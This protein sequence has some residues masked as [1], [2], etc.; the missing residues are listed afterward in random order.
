L[1][2]SLHILTSSMVALNDD[3]NHSRFVVIYVD[4]DG[5]PISFPLGNDGLAL[6]TSFR[7]SLRFRLSEDF[8]I[9]DEEVYDALSRDLIN[10][11]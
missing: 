11:H 4:G 9:V 7:L 1:V 2:L 3:N 10:T 5:V 8:M 6:V